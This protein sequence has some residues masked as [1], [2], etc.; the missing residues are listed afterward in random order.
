MGYKRPRETHLSFTQKLTKRTPK[1]SVHGM[2]ST[3]TRDS[4]VS[5]TRTND[6]LLHHSEDLNTGLTQ[7]RPDSKQQQ[8]SALEEV[9]PQS[10]RA[11]SALNALS[12]CP[13]QPQW[14]VLAGREGNLSNKNENYHV[15]IYIFS[16]TWVQS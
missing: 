14:V 8:R 13:Q 7:H 4:P 2:E 10:F 3:T 15:V 9:T 16:P 12:M 11:N 6:F 5:S 1:R